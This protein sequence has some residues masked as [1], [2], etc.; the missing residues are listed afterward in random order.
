[1]SQQLALNSFVD[2]AL[3]LAQQQQYQ[4]G[5]IMPEFG[6]VEKVNT[7]VRREDEVIRDETMGRKL[8]GGEMT[9]TLRRTWTSLHTCAKAN[10]F[11][12][13]AQLMGKSIGAKGTYK[14]LRT[15]MVLLPGRTRTRGRSKGSRY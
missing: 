7:K 13:A 8:E 12:T 4:H 2:C 11:C 14:V 10:W 5:G 15:Q 3:A 6:V 1:M 9:N